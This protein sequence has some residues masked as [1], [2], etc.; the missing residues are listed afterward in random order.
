MADILDKKD[1]P[2]MDTA[3]LNAAASIMVSGKADNMLDGVE[4]AYES[5]MQGK[6]KE[7][8]EQLIEHTN[9]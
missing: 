2:A 5:V 3:V 7:K 8:L 4:M 6:A 1:G 9:K